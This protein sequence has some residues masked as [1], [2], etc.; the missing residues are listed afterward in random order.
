MTV[1]SW[2]VYS[3]VVSLFCKILVI[4]SNILIHVSVL[5]TCVEG[6]QHLYYIILFL[7]SVTKYMLYYCI[8]L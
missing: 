4:P 1:H 3:C 7:C 2:S 5:S 8:V 6:D